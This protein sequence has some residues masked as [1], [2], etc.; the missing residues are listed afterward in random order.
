MKLLNILLV[1]KKKKLMLLVKMKKIT[2]DLQLLGARKQE[3]KIGTYNSHIQLHIEFFRRE[4]GIFHSRCIAL[5][6]AERRLRKKR[7]MSQREK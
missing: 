4:K 3:E 6:H 1:Q 5:F 7:N 2:S